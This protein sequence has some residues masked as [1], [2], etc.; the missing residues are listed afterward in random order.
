MKKLPKAIRPI[1]DTQPAAAASAA[2]KTR[3]Q[4]AATRTARR[5]A[6]PG[7]VI[8]PAAADLIETVAVPLGPTAPVAND[9]ALSVAPRRTEV[10]NT[11]RRERAN[12]IVTR[13]SASAAAGGLGPVAL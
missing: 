13:Y 10:E 5:T 2:T 9:A 7:D 12:T 11:K 4:A 3:T 8:A 1:S 6:A